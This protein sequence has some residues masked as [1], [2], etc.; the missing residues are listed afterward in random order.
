[1]KKYTFAFALLAIVALTACGTGS[2]TT[3]QTDSTS[4]I[5][6]SSAVNAIDSTVVETS[7]DS[8]LTKEEVK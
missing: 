8:S 6:D 2:T 5:V 4:V 1:M 3:E 7:T